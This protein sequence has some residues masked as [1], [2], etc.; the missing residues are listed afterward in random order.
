[1]ESLPTYSGRK[2]RLPGYYHS[3]VIIEE[4]DSENEQQNLLLEYKEFTKDCVLIG[5]T[6]SVA[7]GLLYLINNQ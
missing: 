6:M 7:F 5:I 1:M 4:P 3:I 2:D